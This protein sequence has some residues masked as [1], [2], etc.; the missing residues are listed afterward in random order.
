LGSFDTI[1]PVGLHSAQAR[2]LCFD[3][4]SAFRDMPFDVSE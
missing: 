2:L 1:T 4:P 3:P